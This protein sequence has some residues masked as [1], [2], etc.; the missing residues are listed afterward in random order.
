M[1]EGI[2]V[3]T[4]LQKQLQTASILLTLKMGKIRTKK[5]SLGF[6]GDTVSLAA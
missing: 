6:M 5:P 2:S 1:E 4:L 3:G